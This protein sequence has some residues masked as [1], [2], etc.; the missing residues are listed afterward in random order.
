MSAFG[1]KADIGAGG[2]DAV[3][4]L[5][6]DWVGRQRHEAGGAAEYYF[7]AE[8]AR[9]PQRQADLRRVSVGQVVDVHDVGECDAFFPP[10]AA[11]DEGVTDVEH[12]V[13]E[14]ERKLLDVLVGGDRH[15]HGHDHKRQIQNRVRI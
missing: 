1:G 5:F 8:H 12:F 3:D 9:P 4:Q 11:H 6:N 14:I 2:I 15:Q 7:V 13:D 10:A